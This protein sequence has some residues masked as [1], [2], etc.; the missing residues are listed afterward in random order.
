MKEIL[1][2]KR[3]SLESHIR[4]EF[5]DYELIE[6]KNSTFMM[7]LSKLLF[8]NKEFMTKYITVIG[9]KVYVPELP[10]SEQKPLTACS[11]LAHEWVH[12]KDGKR[13]GPLFKFLYLFPQ[14]LTPLALLGM[15]NPV[16]LLF[17]GCLLPIPSPFRAW[18]E[19]RAYTITI[20][21]R[22]WLTKQTTSYSWLSKQFTSSAYYWMLPAEQYLQ[23]Q[24]AKEF[25]RIQ[26]DDLK[27]YEEE[28][29]KAL[30]I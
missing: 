29:K 24:F 14:I 25:D 18:F 4:E 26:A 20:A 21:V 13:Y 15:W 8:F 12:M 10:W 17:L 16:F 6:K 22:W 23:K 30:K 11:V 3:K 7:W 2:L 28:I 27:P 9:H 19:F 5:P 1:T